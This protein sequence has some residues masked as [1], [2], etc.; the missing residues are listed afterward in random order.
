MIRSIQKYFSEIPPVFVDGLTFVLI[1][2]F[3][4]WSAAFGSDEAEK[5]ISQSVLYWLRNGCA[6]VA[7]ALLA[8]KMYRSEG[9][10]RHTQDKEKKRET[11]FFQKVGPR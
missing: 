3:G 2:F 9:F 11:E 5:H 6:S 8:L 4:A 10:A 1:A 7:A